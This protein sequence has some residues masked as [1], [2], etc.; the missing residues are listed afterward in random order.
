[1][2]KIC[3]SGSLALKKRILEFLTLKNQEGNNEEQVINQNKDKINRNNVNGKSENSGFTNCI[4]FTYNNFEN[5]NNIA[6]KG[7][8][9][10]RGVINKR[11]DM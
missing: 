11:V 6:L 2:K 8:G 10:M 9:N 4:N 7:T 1:M 5:I 3:R